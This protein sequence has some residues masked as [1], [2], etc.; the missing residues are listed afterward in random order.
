M[1]Q[2]LTEQQGNDAR[3]LQRNDNWIIQEEKKNKFSPDEGREFTE[4]DGINM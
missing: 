3:P 4:R 2:I 1:H